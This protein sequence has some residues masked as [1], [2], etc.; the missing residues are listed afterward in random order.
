MTHENLPQLSVAILKRTSCDN[1]A[2]ELLAEALNNLSQGVVRADVVTK[3]RPL[4]YHHLIRW[5]CTDSYPRPDVSTLNVTKE[6]QLVANKGLFRAHLQMCG[7]GGCIPFTFFNHDFLDSPTDPWF[8]RVEDLDTYIARPTYHAKGANFHMVNTREEAAELI[9]E[10]GPMYFQQVINVQRELR[11]MFA[12]GKVVQVVERKLNRNGGLAPQ[13][14]NNVVNIKWGDWPIQVLRDVM[15]AI[16]DRSKMFGAMDVLVDERGRGY[17]AEIN[18]APEIYPYMAKC[19][20]KALLAHMGVQPFAA[21]KV[22][23]LAPLDH[24]THYIHPAVLKG[25]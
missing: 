23:P 7:L 19:L 17:M 5:G 25:G 9:A 24:Y 6:I 1:G 14:E 22:E 8:D 20:G 10:H 21:Q 3:H 12:H 18:T 15:P 16:Q 13:N 11:I 4:T 2:P